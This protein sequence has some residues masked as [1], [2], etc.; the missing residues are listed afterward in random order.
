VQTAIIGGYWYRRAAASRKMWELLA[1]AVILAADAADAV[2]TDDINQVADLMNAGNMPHGF[3][4]QLLQVE[5]W[6]TAG[7]K[8]S[9][10]FVLDRKLIHATT[11]VRVLFQVVAG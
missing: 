11:E 6:Q 5:G 3:L 1:G 10:T 9:A 2:G 7:K 4:H 8:N